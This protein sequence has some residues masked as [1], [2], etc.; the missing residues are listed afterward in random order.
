MRKDKNLAIRLRKQGKSYNEIAR[1]LNAPKSTLSLWLRDVKMP[2]EIEKKFWDKTRKKW[3][4]SI[5]QFNKKR[6]RLAKEKAK[7]LQKNAAKDIGALSE[8]EL[9]LMGAAL[10]WAEGYKKRLR[11]T[12]QFCNSDPAMIKFMMKFF[13]E[14]CNVPK[15]KIKASAQIHPN[16]TPE[17][18]INY[19]SRISGISKKQFT[20]TYS[21][22]SSSSKQKRPSNR[23]PYGTLR[24]VICD[25]QM[26]NKIKGWIQGIKNQV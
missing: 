18:A 11:W 12:L 21:R 15:E 5:T 7:K 25:T 13:K 14:V 17:K 3:A 23:L 20:K 9:F 8:R 16:V 19:W 10:Y 4:R 1:I 24:I 6:G 22:I 2:P 26:A